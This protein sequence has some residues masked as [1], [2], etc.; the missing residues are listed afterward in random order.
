MP[1]WLG[2]LHLAKYEYTALHFGKSLGKNRHWQ[3]C[4]QQVQHR[5]KHLIQI[6]RRELGAPTHA[7]Q[8]GTHVFKLLWREF[9][10]VAV[11]RNAI[12]SYFRKDR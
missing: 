6:Y 9:A 10:Y 1:S 2:S 8:Q 5:A 3:C 12:F 4:A 11:S 7:L